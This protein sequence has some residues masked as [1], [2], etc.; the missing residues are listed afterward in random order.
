M[1]VVYN[2]IIFIVFILWSIVYLPFVLV[3]AVVG[4]IG[5][6]CFK[7]Y[8]R[9]ACWLYGRI[10]LVL[11]YPFLPVQCNFREIPQKYAP[12]ILV[13]N[14]QSFLDLFLLAAQNES[15][16]CMVSKSW[17]YTK[18]FFYAPF[19]IAA[20]YLNI[21]RLDLESSQH[22][23]IK[24]LQE[25]ATLVIFPE[26]HRSRE[27]VL[28]KFHS[29]AFAVSFITKR[30]IVPLILYNSFQV[31]RSADF[32]LNPTKITLQVLDPVFPEQFEHETVPHRAMMRSVHA[33][34]E[35]A[36]QRYRERQNKIENEDKRSNL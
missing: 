10:L 20:G 28:Q 4:L 15:N 12:C 31:T 8:M 19:M 32:C 18:L 13:C 16:L 2:I 1:R 26:G 36:L 34:M 5:T 11:L 9:K 14:H 27:G 7:K 25:G 21:E 17:P 24:R 6:S 23:L 30:P 35:E 22:M 3:L 33:R 29:G